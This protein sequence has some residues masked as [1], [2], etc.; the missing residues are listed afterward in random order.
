MNQEYNN[1]IPNQIA[2]NSMPSVDIANNQPVIEQP[3]PTGMA[4]PT[5]PQG[6]TP[7]IV[8]GVDVS[9]IS[10]FELDEDLIDEMS[11]EQAELYLVGRSEEEIAA[12]NEK[13]G[14]SVSMVLSDE[15]LAKREAERAGLSINVGRTTSSEPAAP[16]E[17]TVVKTEQTGSVI[18]GVKKQVD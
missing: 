3:T 18:F 6:R 12:F 5:A 16:A 7:I 4:Q 14:F 10:A 9:Q 2:S 13:N 17:P 15:E 11:E 1:A 8:N